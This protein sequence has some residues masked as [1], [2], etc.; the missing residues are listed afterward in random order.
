[1]VI[2]A[3]PIPQATL[4]RLLDYSPETGEM[5]W[6]VNR[7]GV[8]AGTLAGYLS[9]A[10]YCF[11]SVNNRMRLRSRLAFCWM[12]GDY[13]EFV[14]HANGI[15]NDDRWENLRACTRQ[16]NNRNKDRAFGSGV[17]FHKHTGKWRARI[18]VDNRE[19][20]LG[21][22]TDKEEALLVRAKKEIE[23]FG[24]FSPLFCRT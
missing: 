1:M 17:S 21:L 24:E 11:I 15:R 12:T 23:L 19:I 10:G 16:E 9:P 3:L 8:K 6:R 14:D 7:G 13:P 4:K 18:R 22:F 5:H 2:K 20:Y